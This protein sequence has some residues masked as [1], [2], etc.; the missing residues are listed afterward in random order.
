VGIIKKKKL[1]QIRFLFRLGDR[2]RLGQ[3]VPLLPRTV[4]LIHPLRFVDRRFGLPY[5]KNPLLRHP[6]SRSMIDDRKRIIASHHATDL[7]L[8]V[9]RHAMRLRQ[10][11][12]RDLLKFRDVSP[13]EFSGW[14]LIAD[15]FGRRIDPYRI[16]ASSSRLH[17]AL[18]EMYPRLE[19]Q[20]ILRKVHS[21]RTPMQP[22][23]IRCKRHQQRSH[24]EVDPT[25]LGKG[26]HA[27]IDH[28]I[29]GVA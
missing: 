17:L 1:T 29:T 23:M 10:V 15:L 16:D 26:P 19:I 5:R 11:L 27:C 28:R 8:H 20:K 24:T 4:L 3:R 9:H 25:I 2:F 14:V 18:G 7:R 6:V 21:R 12:I 13:D 22:Q